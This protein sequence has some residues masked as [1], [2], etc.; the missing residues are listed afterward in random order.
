MWWVLKEMGVTMKRVRDKSYDWLYNID[1]WQNICML[2]LQNRV[3]HV[4]YNSYCLS[5]IEYVIITTCL[6]LA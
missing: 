3:E 2:E 5:T 4:L 6:S 1:I